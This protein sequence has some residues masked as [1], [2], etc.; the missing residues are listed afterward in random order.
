MIKYELCLTSPFFTC[1]QNENPFFCAKLFSPLL[2]L[3][4]AQLVLLFRKHG[5]ARANRLN[6]YDNKI[7]GQRRKYFL[8]ISSA[9]R[10][11]AAAPF[12]SLW[13][14]VVKTEI[15]PFFIIGAVFLWLVPFAILW[16][17]VFYPSIDLSAPALCCSNKT[18][19][20]SYA[21]P[22]YITGPDRGETLCHF[23]WRLCKKCRN[24][25]LSQPRKEL[26]E[27]N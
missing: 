2:Y 20:H 9:E 7:W 8:Y 26:D 23:S 6:K 25:F 11:R 22:I 24:G 12:F 10:K 15:E 5:R 13:P 27:L 18:D 1:L 21:S 19:F 16:H 17:I 3:P 4:M 14:S